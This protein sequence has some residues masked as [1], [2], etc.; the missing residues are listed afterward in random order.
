[1][2]TTF[3]QST[4]VIFDMD[5]VL[6]D[7]LGTLYQIYHDILE[8]YG[9]ASCREE[10]NLLNGPSMPEVVAILR[11]RHP[12]LPDQDD[13]L[14]EFSQRQSHLYEL[15]SLHPEVEQTLT[16]LRSLGVTIALASS[17]AK[18]H[19][20]LILNRYDLRDYFAVI[21]SG[22]DVVEAKP[23]PEIYLRA[24]QQLNC[25]Y[26]YAIDD[27]FNGVQSALAAGISCIQFGGDQVNRKHE[28]ASYRINQLSKLVQILEQ[29]VQIQL[30]DGPFELGVTDD[31]IQ[32]YRQLV[33]DEWERRSD[34]TLFDGSAM[35]LRRLRFDQLTLL[36]GS[37]RMAYY[38]MHNPNSELAR[39][40]VPDRCFRFRV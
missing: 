16:E 40:V 5:G 2:L 7:T 8:G 38:L 34:S 14:R 33:D 23:N 19:I 29:P 28:R 21:I 30:R 35:F 4:G 25:L 27:S 3:V 12:Q 22:D 26:M 36:Q 15:A 11:Q 39:Q 13:L 37:Y 24:A 1:M 6:V 17:A 20:E 31:D 32:P 10:F 9:I 18:K